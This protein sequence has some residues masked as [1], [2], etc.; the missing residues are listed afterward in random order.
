MKLKFNTIIIIGLLINS[1]T[2]SPPSLPPSTPTK[3]DTYRPTYRP[4]PQP[5]Y[6]SVEKQKEIY[7]ELVKIQDSGRYTHQA[8]YNVIATRYNISIQ[9]VKNIAIEG[10]KA[11]WKRP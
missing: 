9:K 1:C 7:Y 6:L 11:D 2:T 5:T 4:K 3:R 8:T 10:I